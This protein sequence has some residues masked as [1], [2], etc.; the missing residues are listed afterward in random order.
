M[1]GRDG[2]LGEHE[3]VEEVINSWWPAL[4]GDNRRRS[5]IDTM[6]DGERGPNRW[7]V[8]WRVEGRREGKGQGRGG[9]GRCDEW[10]LGEVLR[11]LG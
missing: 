11:P 5:P 6:S 8:T 2:V 1:F 9:N 4:M 7:L 10:I 3:V